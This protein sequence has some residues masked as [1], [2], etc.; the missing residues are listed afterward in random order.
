MSWDFDLVDPVTRKT[1]TTDTKHHMKGGTYQIG[2]SNELSLN[3]TYNYSK[4][5]YDKFDKTLQE[6][7]IEPREHQSYAEYLRD[8]TGAETIPI[9]KGTIEKLGDDVDEDYWK[10]TEGNAKQALCMLLAMAQMRPDG[11]W[12]VC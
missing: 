7:G 6:L 10:A 1:L 5:I 9:L 2:G 4:M 12:E 8:K 11:I 3:V